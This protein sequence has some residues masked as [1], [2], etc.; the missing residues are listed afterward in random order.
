MLVPEHPQPV[1]R[2]RAVAE[3]M[4]AA[5]QAAPI[6]PGHVLELRP[7]PAPAPE[8]LDAAAGPQT[9]GE[10]PLLSRRGDDPPF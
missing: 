5:K 10:S 2:R 1:G 9:A 4:V 6:A 8:P 3:M 7:A